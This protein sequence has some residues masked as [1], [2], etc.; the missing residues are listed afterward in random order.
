MKK[1]LLFI[2]AAGLLSAA[3][4]SFKDAPSEYARTNPSAHGGVLSYSSTVSAAKKSVVNIAT[5]RT[6]KNNFHSMSP[7]N[8]PFFEE[9]F[10]FKFNMPQNQQNQKSNALGSGVIISNDGYIVTN[11][12]VV[13]DSDEITVT[14]LD[15]Y[16]E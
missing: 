9:F 10:G 16:K 1:A 12:H 7:F 14:M 2:C 4:I 15:S 13:E 3:S 11:N 8:D 5:S 6:V